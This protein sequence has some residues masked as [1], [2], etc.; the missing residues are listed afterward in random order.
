MQLSVPTIGMLSNMKRTRQLLYGNFEKMRY[1]FIRSPESDPIA[2]SIHKGTGSINTVLRFR[3][4]RLV[5]E[6]K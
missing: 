1:I 3:L 6:C 5:F 2:N 4:G